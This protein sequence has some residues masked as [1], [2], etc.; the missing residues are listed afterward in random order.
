MK[1]VI[2]GIVALSVLACLH[3]G[4]KFFESELNAFF[5]KDPAWATFWMQG[6]S[7]FMLFVVYGSILF[8]VDMTASSSLVTKLKLQPTI[9][10]SLAD[11][12]KAVRVAAVN[13]FILGL[14]FAW[15]M[16][17]ILIPYRMKYPTIFR[18][19]NNP[20]IPNIVEFFVH[21]GVAVFFEEI[22]FFYSHKWLHEPK[23][24]AKIHKLHH[25]F[26]SPFGI[27]AVYAHPYEH[28][29]ANMLPL[30][31]GPLIMGSSPFVGCCWTCFGLFTTMT[32]HCGYQFP[33]LP[34]PHFHDWH[35]ETF[36]ENFG[37][38]GVM[39]TLY[40]TSKKFQVSRHMVKE[41]K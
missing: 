7:P 22:L 38:L 6:I 28:F 19:E 21:V 11:Y 5:S 30:V 14:P 31:V 4:G 33:F 15:I 25:N 20:L 2:D 24:Y 29:L 13:W 32:H 1:P 18:A 41:K 9:R 39:D 12:S 3:A 10:P 17:F 26:T 40:G 16:S 23:Q 8:I 34:S 35:H 27:A 36:N 37:V